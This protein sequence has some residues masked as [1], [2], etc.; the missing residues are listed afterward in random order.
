MLAVAS[1]MVWFWSGRH[2]TGDPAVDD[3]LAQVLVHIFFVKRLGKFG[4]SSE[5][6]DASLQ[7]GDD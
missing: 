4:A 5:K 3:A 6:A 1:T 2:K 7:S